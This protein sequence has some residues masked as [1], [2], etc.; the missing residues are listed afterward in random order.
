[1]KTVGISSFSIMKAFYS[2]KGISVI[3]KTVAP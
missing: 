1:M 3:R 2:V